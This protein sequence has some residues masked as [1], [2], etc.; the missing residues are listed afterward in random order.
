MYLWTANSSAR[1][2]SDQTLCRLTRAILDRLQES[3]SANLGSKDEETFYG[4][5]KQIGTNCSIA[6]YIG[7]D[8]K[9]FAPNILH[10]FVTIMHAALTIYIVLCGESYVPAIKREDEASCVLGLWRAYF[11]V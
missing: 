10:V 7:V 8:S 9:L 2:Y 3:Y 11:R 1:Q 5:R 4:Q 6:M